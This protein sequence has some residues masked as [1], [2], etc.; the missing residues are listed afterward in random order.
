MLYAGYGLLSNESKAQSGMGPRAN[1]AINQPAYPL[2]PL[3]G[4]SSI[5]GMGIRHSF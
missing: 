4:N 5:V 3:G 1:A 2:P